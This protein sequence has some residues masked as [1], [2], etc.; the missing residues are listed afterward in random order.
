MHSIA[1][2]LTAD[3][4]AGFSAE[5]LSSDVD[6]ILSYIKD[7]KEVCFVGEPINFKCS[8]KTNS[9]D[10]Q[11]VQR[12]TCSITGW[13]KQSFLAAKEVERCATYDGRIG[14]LSCWFFFRVCHKDRGRSRNCQSFD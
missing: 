11:P 10:L 9:Q 14:F 2:L 12:I 4:V 7:R 3:E 13:K 8:E 6:V 5:F 1:P